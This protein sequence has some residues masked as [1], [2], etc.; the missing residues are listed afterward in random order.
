M[1]NSI[2]NDDRNIA[3]LAS[4]YVETYLNLAVVNVNQKTAD[5]SAVASFSMIAG[6]TCFFVSMFSGIAASLWIGGLLA[7]NAVG[8]LLVA[9]FF[10]LIF[11]VLFLS[12][13]KIF[14]PFVKNLIVKSIYE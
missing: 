14:Y 6:L 8:F 9:V 12:R 5:I 4:D 7:N 2:N 11:L 3:E 10:L 1:E 13:K